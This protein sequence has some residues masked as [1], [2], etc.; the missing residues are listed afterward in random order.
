M[1]TFTSNEIKKLH[2]CL[3]NATECGIQNGW[4]CGTCFFDLSTSLDNP[5]WQL[6]LL[7][8]GG[9]EEEFDN[10]PKDR[11]ASYNKI[12]TACND[13]NKQMN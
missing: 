9:S 2:N 13:R 11:R 5:D 3:T 1:K 10:L 12:I 4:C 6:V 7:L 8:R